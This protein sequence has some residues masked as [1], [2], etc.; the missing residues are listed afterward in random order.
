MDYECFTVRKDVKQ[1]GDLLQC[2]EKHVATTS[3]SVFAHYH[4]FDFAGNRHIILVKHLIASQWLC[5]HLSHL[6]V[7]YQ[8]VVKVLPQSSFA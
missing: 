5:E 1:P 3:A 2:S 6:A 4:S 8:P 7:V